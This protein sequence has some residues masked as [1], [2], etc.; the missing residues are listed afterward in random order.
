LF[1]YRFGATYVGA[2]RVI[3]PQEAYPIL[4]GDIDMAGNLQAHIIDAP[5]KNIRFTIIWFIRMNEQ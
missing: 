4:L 1:N 3:S 2:S 5:T